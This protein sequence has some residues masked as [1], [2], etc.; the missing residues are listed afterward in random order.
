MDPTIG[1]LLSSLLLTLS[2]LSGK[3]EPARVLN[4]QITVMG[5]VYCDICSNN[6]F[7]HHSYFLPG[8]EVKIDCMFDAIS[9]RTMEQISFTV[10]RTT[11]KHGVYK[12]VIPSVDGIE[13]ARAREVGNFCRASLVSSSTSACNVAGYRSTSDEF[14]VKS[15]E[16]NVCFYTLSAMNYRPSKRNTTLCG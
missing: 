12:L 1:C 9:P 8:A 13:C 11:D 2:L 6:T 7:S 3:V 10:N 16:T 14:A 15:E 4:P 5:I